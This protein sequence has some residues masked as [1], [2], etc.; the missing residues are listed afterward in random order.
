MEIEYNFDRLE[1]EGEWATLDTGTTF[2]YLTREIK[3]QLSKFFD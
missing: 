2:L 3:N 1:K